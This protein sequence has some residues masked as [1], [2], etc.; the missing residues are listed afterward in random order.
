VDGL[1]IFC[2]YAIKVKKKSAR[3]VILKYEKEAPFKIKEKE[4]SENKMEVA[5][6]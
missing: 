1:N 6:L 3:F 5:D 4:K 2:K